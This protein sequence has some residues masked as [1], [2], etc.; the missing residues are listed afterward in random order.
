MAN[1][2]LITLIG[3]TTT[4]PELRFVPSGA[5]VANFTV[6]STPKMFDKRTNEW[7][8]QETLFMRCN[9]WREQAESV[10]ESITKGM[11]VV[12]T[13]RL[14]SRSWED[15]DGTKRTVV[16]LEVDEIG[17]SLK[18]AT[19]KVQRT[20]RNNNSSGFG[21]QQSQPSGFGPSTAQQDPWATPG[22]SNGG[23]WGN[24]PDSEPPF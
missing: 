22:V 5:A 14:T 11:R 17:P 4:D 21:N 2:T 13:G 15:K 16:E 19:A 10:A 1:E 24:G 9:V 23:G 3:N 6:A 18:Y 20:Q 12:V 8:D 7:K